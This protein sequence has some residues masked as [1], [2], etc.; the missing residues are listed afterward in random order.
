LAS[1]TTSTYD[2][3]RSNC[4]QSTAGLL[5][6]GSGSHDGSGVAHDR[7]LSH[8]RDD[9]EEQTEQVDQGQRPDSS[10]NG[11]DRLALQD[12]RRLPEHPRRAKS[13]RKVLSDGLPEIFPHEGARLPEGALRTKGSAIQEN[14]T[15]PITGTRDDDD[16]KRL[17]AESMQREEKAARKARRINYES[18][19]P[20]DS[21]DS[22]QQRRSY[23]KEDDSPLR[24][25][26]GKMKKL[27]LAH[28]APT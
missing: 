26:Q 22:A 19:I 25:A 13:A 10:I 21:F 9:K 11:D 23:K 27:E 12:D 8:D 18:A 16:N 15:L 14:P 6:D 28:D 3:D 7:V 24:A 20:A 5:V 4:G 1:A 2:G 17:R